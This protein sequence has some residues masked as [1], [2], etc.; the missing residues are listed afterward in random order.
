MKLIGL[1]FSV[2]LMQ[3]LPAQLFYIYIFQIVGTKSLAQI[4]VPYI[5]FVSSSI[6]VDLLVAS[7]IVWIFFRQSQLG[8]RIPTETPGKNWLIA[9]IVLY[10][11]YFTPQLLATFVE[12]G[13]FFMS[14]H[15]RF[16]MPIFINTC[17]VVG[18]VKVLLSVAPISSKR[19]DGD[20][21]VKEEAA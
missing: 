7:L 11:A 5:V 12:G 13:G 16:Y 19:V 18:V 14:A 21:G 10:V 8:D 3:I 9:G 4:N 2:A 20:D 6:L 15:Y 17:F 1:G